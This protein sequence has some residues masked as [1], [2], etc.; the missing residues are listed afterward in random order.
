MLCKLKQFLLSIGGAPI[1]AKNGFSIPTVFLKE[2]SSRNRRELFID[3]SP[4]GIMYIRSYCTVRAYHTS[5]FLLLCSEKRKKKTACMYPA[6]LQVFIS[7]VQARSVLH[8]FFV[9]EN[10]W[11]W[12]QQC[13]GCYIYG[14]WYALKSILAEST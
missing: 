7:D 4:A 11:L 3:F 8:L 12:P 1:F 10:G 13:N 2:V 14:F 6:I 9:D 5:T